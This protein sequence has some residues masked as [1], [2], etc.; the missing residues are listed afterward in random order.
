MGADASEEGLQ[1]YKEV[2]FSMSV[3]LIEKRLAAEKE[4]SLVRRA[5]AETA[6]RS[7][8]SLDIKRSADWLAVSAVGF[9]RKKSRKVKRPEPWAV[10]R[11]KLETKLLEL[12]DRDRGEFSQVKF[13]LEECDMG[14]RIR[15]VIKPFGAD[16]RRCPPVLGA[17]NII[18]PEERV[19]A[20]MRGKT[21]VLEY[22]PL[23]KRARWLPQLFQIKGTQQFP[24]LGAVVDALPDGDDGEIR[25]YEGVVFT[26]SSGNL[27]VKQ[28]VA[29]S[30]LDQVDA[31][32]VP[33]RVSDWWKLVK[34]IDG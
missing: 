2:R 5:L 12:G 29:R 18:F 4:M 3:A 19:E 11:R 16:I 24:I 20:V 8:Y 1:I 6:R 30:G 13:Y 25:L 33:K 32:I 27:Q 9:A 21:S 23:Q 34:R 14:H 22:G 26:A 31:V 10:I 17:V 7:G 15:Y 28:W